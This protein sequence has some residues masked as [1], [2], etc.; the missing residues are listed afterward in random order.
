MA[1]SIPV[2]LPPFRFPTKT[3]AEEVIRNVLTRNRG[4]DLAG[5]DLQLA[6]AVLRAHPH[7]AR[8]LERGYAGM[9]VA[10]DPEYGTWGLW[11]LTED[12]RL[13]DVSYRVAVG[14]AKA[15]PSLYTAGRALLKDAMEALRREAFAAG[16]VVCSVSNKPLHEG[17]AHVDHAPPHTF[18]KIVRSYIEKYGEPQLRHEGTI[19]VF[20]DPIEAERFR[21]YHDERAE[22]R[23]VDRRVNMSDLRRKPAHA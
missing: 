12:G 3:A 10:Q 20:V 19:D 13:V 22:L 23:I 15:D 9:R 5:D 14:L 21:G 4:K 18:D 6:E 17:E 11:L 7:A 2:E 8:K 16:P 1:R